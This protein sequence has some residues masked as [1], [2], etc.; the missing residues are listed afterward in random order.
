MHGKKLRGQ[1]VSKIT[2]LNICVSYCLVKIVFSSS[3]KKITILCVLL[4]RM[5]SG[6]L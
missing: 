3:E 1:R 4:K 5:D 2:D 6:E